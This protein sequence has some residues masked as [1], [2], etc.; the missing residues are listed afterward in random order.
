MSQRNRTFKRIL[1]EV[2]S[3]VEVSVLTADAMDKSEGLRGAGDLLDQATA[4]F[5]VC[6]HENF[7]VLFGEW[8]LED[9]GWYGSW[10][11]QQLITIRVHTWLRLLVANVLDGD[12]DDLG[13]ESV[14]VT[15][16][17]VNES[18]FL[19]VCSAIPHANLSR[20]R[21]SYRLRLS[22]SLRHIC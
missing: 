1:F 3:I 15:V 22:L 19:P 8:V 13:R 11:S 9:F 21:A 20:S 5:E 17:D 7:L 16:R 6:R 4:F 10:A 18:I 2:Q 14:C 12:V